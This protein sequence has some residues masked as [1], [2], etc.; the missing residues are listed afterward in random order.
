MAADDPQGRQKA[1]RRAADPADKVPVGGIELGGISFDDG[2]AAEAQILF[3]VGRERGEGAPCPCEFRECGDELAD[4]GDVLRFRVVVREV[5]YDGEEVRGD[6]RVESVGD[7]SRQELPKPVAEVE[8]YVKGRCHDLAQEARHF[9][10]LRHRRC[11]K[12]GG[13]LGERRVDLGNCPT[14]MLAVEQLKIHVSHIRSKLFYNIGK[15]W[16]TTMALPIAPTPYLEGRDALRFDRIV[17]DGLRNRI[18]LTQ[19]S[20]YWDAMHRIQRKI[21]A[22]EKAGVAR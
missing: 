14:P 11:P 13:G 17:A 1:D 18:V 5:P 9:L 16:E 22:A 2:P 12:D 21:A 4:K 10:R 6:S 8:V 19:P 15:S 3:F 20:V 7:F